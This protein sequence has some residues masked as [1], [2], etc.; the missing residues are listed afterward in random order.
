MKDL[1]RQSISYKLH[2]ASLNGFTFISFLAIVY[3]LFTMFANVV[4]LVA[5]GASLN[6]H[7]YIHLAERDTTGRLSNHI[8]ANERIYPL[9]Q[10]NQ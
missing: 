5:G 1:N 8:Q 9:T 6:E 4:N 7:Y 2:H 3:V 10:T